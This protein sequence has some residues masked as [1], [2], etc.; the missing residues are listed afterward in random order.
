MELTLTTFYIQLNLKYPWKECEVHVMGVWLEPHSLSSLNTL[1][2]TA[3]Y[4]C[5]AK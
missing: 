5:S 3:G 2:H 4:M 1:G